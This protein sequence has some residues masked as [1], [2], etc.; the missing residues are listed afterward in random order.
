MGG[1]RLAKA[2][3]LS[4]LEACDASEKMLMSGICVIRRFILQLWRAVVL[5]FAANA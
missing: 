1:R 5:L 2:H 4:K 3:L